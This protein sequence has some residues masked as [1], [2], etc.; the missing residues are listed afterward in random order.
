[1]DQ[2]DLA[3]LDQEHKGRLREH[4]CRNLIFM[5]DQENKSQTTETQAKLDE[6][7]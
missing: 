1:M 7:S 5:E 6:I 2:K 4:G 3:R